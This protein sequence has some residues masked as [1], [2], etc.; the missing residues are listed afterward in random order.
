MN[1]SCGRCDGQRPTCSSCQSLDLDCQY[2]PSDSATNIVVRKDYV[3]DIEQRVT[4]VEKLLQRLNDVVKG[5]LSPCVNNGSA[6]GPCHPANVGR[7]LTPAVNVTQTNETRAIGLEEPQ[8]ED[9]TTNGMA[10]TFAEEHT[11]A[12]FG[13]SS[14]VG[15][16][17]LLLQ[18][19]AA[20][21]R[22]T[23]VLPPMTDKELTSG[24][25]FSSSFPQGPSQPISASP[26][27]S[28][29]ALPSTEEMDNLLDVYFSTAGVVFPFIHEETMRKTYAECKL[30]G[31]TKARRTWLGT[32]NMIFAMASTF[33]RDRVASARERAAKSNVFYKRA[34]GLCGELSKRVIS[35][36]IVHY[37]LLVVIHC[38]GTQRSIQSWNNHG[39][40]IRSAMAL[41]LHSPSTGNSV[42]PVQVEYRRR[43][44]VVIYCLDKVLS[45]A[46]GR[47]AGVPDEQVVVREPTWGPPSASPD[48]THHDVD[49]PGEFLAVSFRLYQVM[50]SS[51]S[52]QY[53]ANVEQAEHDM[54]D[55]ASLKASGELRKTLRLWAASLPSYLRLCAP[56]LD[57][58]LEKSQANRLRVI[59]TLRYHNLGILVH[60]PLLSAT[61][62]QLFLKDRVPGA[63]PP[64]LMQLAMAEAHECIRSA[65]STILIAHRI[66]SVDPSSKNNL[67]MGFYTLYYGQS[68]AKREIL[69]HCLLTFTTVFTASLVIIASLLWAQHGHDVPDEGAVAHTRSLL[70][71]TEIIFQR[72]DH[73]NNLVFSCLEHI[74]RFAKMCNFKG[75]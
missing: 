55:M 17:Q 38:Q 19:I 44:W 14:N 4:S 51:L 33:D 22:A 63:S 26:D 68:I 21:H 6:S 3:S 34:L 11:S 48:A 58:L 13:E 24:G 16:T 39:L 10:M 20:V 32:L 35:L 67:G 66:I 45:V 7:S 74:R 59:L 49:L 65:E 9:A 73:E 30:N 57:M 28:I 18:A 41:G 42:D 40:A 70:T 31:F 52:K 71:K 23:S 75:Q 60:K 1:A 50:S 61:I 12:F 8:D 5:H 69:L 53:S 46:F 2:E 72:L 15:F 37:L 27:P 47:P 64:Y 29:T 36:E 25:S 56:E 43:T 54:D 62:T